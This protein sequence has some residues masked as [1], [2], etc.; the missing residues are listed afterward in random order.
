MPNLIRLMII[1]IGMMI[2]FGTSGS[3]MASSVTIADDTWMRPYKKN[4]PTGDWTDIPV[5]GNPA[6]WD[7]SRVAVSWSTDG[8]LELM[9]IFTNYRRNGLENAGQADIALDRDHDGVFETG[10]KMSGANLGKIYQ[11][12][13]WYTPSDF[14][15]DT[16]STYTG[17]Y[18]P[19]GVKDPKAPAPNTVINKVSGVLGQASVSWTAGT[20]T[21][22]IINVVFPQDFGVDSSWSYFD[23]TVGSGSCANEF[24]AGSALNPEPLGGNNPVPLPGSVL[25]L[26]SGLVALAGL[27]F[28]REV[29]SVKRGVGR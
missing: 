26:A 29:V 14:W 8:N 16:G 12:S 17:Q 22:Y 9:Q 7:I 20:D 27:R 4:K 18:A 15:G 28:R 3:A 2:I 13:S 19:K 1:F 10:I 11:V 6:K 23:F 5:A 24:M 21:N 25:L